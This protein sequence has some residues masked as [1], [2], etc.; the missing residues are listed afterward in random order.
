[1]T[2]PMITN[3]KDAEELRAKLRAKMM[4]TCIEDRRA[5]AQALDRFRQ[6]VGPIGM[7]VAELI[8]EG[9]RR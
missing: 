1:M 6:R 9:R 5:A 8:R 3:W 4:E 2:Q 7:P